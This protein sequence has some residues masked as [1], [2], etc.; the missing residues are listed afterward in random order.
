MSVSKAFVQS[1][2]DRI[3]PKDYNSQAKEALQAAGLWRPR[4][5]RWEG[6]KRT[7]TVMNVPTHYTYRGGH[8]TVGSANPYSGRRTEYT[9]WDKELGNYRKIPIT[10]Q[11]FFTGGLEDLPTAI[12]EG[13]VGTQ[14]NRQ[15]T[16]RPK[17]KGKLANATAQELDRQEL[18]NKLLADR[19]ATILD[20]RSN[21]MESKGIG[22]SN[23]NYYKDLKADAEAFRQENK[24]AFAQL[25]TNKDVISNFTEQL[26]AQ[27]KGSK[28]RARLN[29]ERKAVIDEQKEI[30]SGITGFD[31]YRDKT[32][33]IKRINTE[34]KAAG[35]R[36]DR[37]LGFLD[38]TQASAKKIAEEKSAFN[39]KY[40]RGRFD[41]NNKK[42][43][44]RF[45]KRKHTAIKFVL[46]T[47]NG[48]K[49]HL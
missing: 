24:D 2:W 16:F 5:A 20:Y 42:A 29:R 1:P 36:A 34:R 43:Q 32:E 41:P 27:A 25:A 19:R 31:E 15:K 49:R 39:E 37:L 33:K 11:N 14:A 10:K 8:N 30:R 45:A 46:K 9:V 35:E 26:Q 40:K 23:S 48:V 38:S 13:G 4:E 22:Q 47:K 6:D 12:D 17:D 18:L 44:E 28:E 3:N 7:G 21:V